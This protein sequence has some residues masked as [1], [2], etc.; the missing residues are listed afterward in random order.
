MR[1]GA[2]A[3]RSE[4]VCVETG[5]TIERQ[6]EGGSLHGLLCVRNSKLFGM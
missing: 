3:V 6:I 4:M 1:R 2:W 5:K